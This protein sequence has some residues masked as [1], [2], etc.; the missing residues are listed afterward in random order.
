MELEH[1][2]SKGKYA[3]I[4]KHNP[5]RDIGTLHRHIE[6][7]QELAK[8]RIHSSTSSQK[9]HVSSDERHKM[10]EDS[11][12]PVTLAEFIT[13]P[14][15][16]RADPA[17]I[18]CILCLLIASATQGVTQ[19]FV[20]NLRNYALRW[21]SNLSML[22]GVESY[23]HFTETDRDHINIM[24]NTLYQHKTLHLSYTG[25]DMQEDTELLRQRRYP[26]IMVLSD[27]EEHPYLYG[28][29]LGLFHIRV[30]N[31]GPCTLLH[32]GSEAVLPIL[33]IRWFKL[34]T[35]Q[36]QPGFH[37]LRYPSVSYCKSDE[38]DA[39]GLIHPDEIIRPIH[40]IPRFKFG[41]TS[42][43]LDGYSMGRP[44]GEDSDW[45]HFSINM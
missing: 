33:W 5:E 23:E 21:T 6:V 39:F 13:T 15:G 44:E 9:E 10:S 20:K 14:H 16:G 7:L 43:Y 40:L 38:P 18:V 12:D 37:S 4:N 11:S 42:E 31:S 8:S 29:V 22:P 34:D 25:Y 1:R 19:D 28:R 45:K 2:S 24:S 30:K 36:E 26:G 17:K 32:N 27:D 41:H 35:T 3:F